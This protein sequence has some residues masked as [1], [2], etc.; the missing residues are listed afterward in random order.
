MPLRSEVVIAA[1][2]RSLDLSM[3]QIAE[4]MPGK[5]SQASVSRW[6][7]EARNA[8]VI[9]RDWRLNVP[10]EVLAE[11]LHGLQEVK[12][13]EQIQSNWGLETC[14]VVAGKRLMEVG[15]PKDQDGAATGESDDKQTRGLLLSALGRAAAAVFASDLAPKL[16]APEDKERVA[17]LAWGR[18]VGA[19]CEAVRLTGS[20]DAAGTR[21]PRLRAVPAIGHVTER[22]PARDQWR[23]SAQALTWSFKDAVGSTLDP[24]TLA[25]PARLPPLLDEAQDD[26]ARKEILASDGGFRRLFIGEDA[27]AGRLDLAVLSVGPILYTAWWPEAVWWEELRRKAEEK[28][29]PELLEENYPKAL[30]A[31][32]VVGDILWHFVQVLGGRTQEAQ[33]EIGKVM[34][35]SLLAIGIKHLEALA[36]RARNGEAAGTLFIAESAEKTDICRAALDLGLVNHLVIDDA[37]AA[38]LVGPRRAGRAAVGNRAPAPGAPPS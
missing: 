26:F 14:I 19:F 20:G 16:A 28:G 12:L 3:D 27:L 25:V 34:N 11:A 31:E 9:E 33:D 24:L 13:Q 30:E 38:G 6:L 29:R 17:A 1:Y 22:E 4:L 18:T 37:L 15:P 8:K 21:L 10:R 35:A 32:G 5:P 2:L 23:F 36:D 7:S